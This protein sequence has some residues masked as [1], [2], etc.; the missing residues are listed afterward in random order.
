MPT[1]KKW[2][3]KKN[4]FLHPFHFCFFFFMFISSSPINAKEW[5]LNLI[6]RSHD[7]VFHNN[8]HTLYSWALLIQMSLIRILHFLGNKMYEDVLYAIQLSGCFIYLENFCGNQS[9]WIKKALLYTKQ[10]VYC[11]PLTCLTEAT[12]TNLEFAATAF[13]IDSRLCETLKQIKEPLVSE[14]TIPQASPLYHTGNI[15]FLKYN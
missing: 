2:M 4:M 9:V 1:I 7:Y 3:Y 10:S 15:I 8:Y 11:D 12:T 6:Y 5:K 14:L 13:G